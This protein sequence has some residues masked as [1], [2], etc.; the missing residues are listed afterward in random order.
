M[1]LA[2]SLTAAERAAAQ[3]NRRS[4]Y[5]LE[6][7][8]PDGSWV[9][10]GAITINGTPTRDFKSLAS[11]SKHIDENT[12]S[13]SATVFREIGN[14]SLAPLRTDSPLNASASFTYQPRLDL[15]RRWRIKVITLPWPALPGS[16]S[17]RPLAE[18]YIT[19]LDIG[20]ERR[21]QMGTITLSGRGQEMPLLKI[22]QLAEVDYAGAAIATRLQA[23]ADRWNAGVTVYPHASAPS[24]FVNAGTAG[25]GALMP[26]LQEIAQLPGA[27]L[28][29]MYDAADV[30]RFTLFTPNRNPS[31]PDWTFGPDEYKAIPVNRLDLDSIKNYIPLTYIDEVAGETTI[32]SPAPEPTTVTAVAGAATFSATP[33]DTLADDAVIVVDGVAYTVSDYDDVAGT[34]TLS[35]APTFTGKAWVTSA[36]ITRYGLLPFPIGLARTTNITKLTDAGAMAD[37]IRSDLEF[38]VLE[39]Q[40]EVEGAWFV[41]PYDYIALEPN[42]THY[43]TTQYGGVTSVTHTFAGGR[44]ITTIGLRGKPAGGYRSW[45]VLG[46]GAGTRAPFVPAITQLSADFYEYFTPGP[47]RFAAVNWLAN[48]NQYT[49]SV[50]V[51][52]S[53]TEDFAVVLETQYADVAAGGTVGGAFITGLTSGTIYYVRA[54]PYS[55]P[56]DAGFP[57]GIAGLPVVDPAFVQMQAPTQASFD[58][59]AEDVEDLE[60]YI[61][62][63]LAG[64]SWKQA[65]R[66]AT[67]TAGTLA[68]SFENADTIDGVTLATGD[69]ILIKDQAAPAENGIYT[70]NAS[71]APTRATDADTGAELVNATCYVS[72]GTANADTA[73]TCTTNAPITLGTT[74]LAFAQAG[75]GGIT[76]LTGDVTAGPGAGSQAA[77]LAA[78]GASAGTYGSSTAI[79]VVTVDAKG[80]VTSVTTTP[81]V[82]GGGGGAAQRQ[83]EG[84]GS[85]D[86]AA[87]MTAVNVSVMTL[88]QGVISIQDL[89]TAS[90]SNTVQYH[91]ENAPSTPWN[92]YLRANPILGSSGN[93]QFGLVVANSASGKLLLFSR[94]IGAAGLTV[95]EWTNPTTFSSSLL[96]APFPSFQAPHWLR[97]NND[98]TTLTMYYSY[99]GLLWVSMGTRTL[100]TFLGSVDR[101]GYGGVPF[102]AGQ[103]WISNFG[104]TTPT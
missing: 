80:R 64:L 61:D 68:S 91:R 69:R 73:W 32:T 62:A 58:S 77:T 43:N 3:G 84:Y 28:R 75:G 7:T 53:E 25:V 87:G 30:N 72:E 92:L 41:E 96:T 65:V 36:S 13:M 89:W 2:R 39:Q 35:G 83:Y 15:R 17:F 88:T 23:Q 51:E 99:D 24:Y 42:G 48:V 100:A 59:L 94:S 90:S 1:S 70:V 22:E 95:Q 66:A 54:T 102:T 26:G 93:D 21:G 5:T 19:T 57:T 9:D 82:G 49:R 14:L 37:A 97:I 98:G 4:F 12:L 55:G 63:R 76:Q 11:I 79:P 47:I 50:K 78:S 86:A 31:A 40:I 52:L 33:G 38:P 6:V 81:V 27:V 56:L 104:T 67:T 71:G 74:A 29:Y 44:L 101:I 103:V 16:T 10:L 60:D 85:L 18:G 34:A 45:L 8:N 46:G 20:G